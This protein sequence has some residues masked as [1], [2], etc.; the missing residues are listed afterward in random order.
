MLKYLIARLFGDGA[1][2]DQQRADFDRS[3]A[4]LESHALTARLTL[5]AET[6]IE[7]E[8]LELLSRDADDDVRMLVAAN[9]AAPHAANLRL[10]QDSV[11]AVRAELAVKIAR[12]VPQL[13][14]PENAQIARLA[15]EVMETLA[16]D[17]ASSV[18]AILAEELKASSQ[19]PRHIV[20]RLARDLE[21]AV[22]GPVLE[23]SPLLSDEDLLEIIAGA[24]AQGA[25]IAIARRN[26]LSSPVSDAVVETYD[27]PAIAALLNNGGARLCQE[28]LDRIAERASGNVPWHRPI[29]MRPGLSLRAIRRLAEFVSANLLE[30]LERRSGLEPALKAHLRSRLKD[31]LSADAEALCA[32]KEEAKAAAR[33]GDA[34]TRGVL[35]QDYVMELVEEGARMAVVQALAAKAR[36]HPAIVGKI[37]AARSGKAITAIVWRAGFNARLALKVQTLVAHVPGTQTVLPRDGDRFALTPEDMN[38]HLEFFGAA[39]A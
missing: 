17:A 8:V 28:T 35:D 5:A 24:R 26:M 7:T 13:S 4:I 21:D 10:A 6:G 3:R 20:Q 22:A 36:I 19:I 16:A 30:T 14:G 33:V 25:L 32:V 2:R 34:L 23:F 37:L 18:R 31:R 38:W 27:V 15:V 29:V 9:P 39:K 12:L 1:D 11:E